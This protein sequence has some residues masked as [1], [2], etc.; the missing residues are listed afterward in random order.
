MT[1]T[2]HP[3]SA[4]NARTV[5][6]EVS[7]SVIPGTPGDAGAIG[8]VTRRDLV[9][10]RLDRLGRRTDE[11]DPFG[12]DRPG[13]V[14]VLGEEAVAG[15]HAVGA[16][17]PDRGEDRLGVEVPL[18]GRLPAERVGLVG[19]PHVQR[20]AVEVGVDRDGRDAELLGTRG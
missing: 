17:R 12:R 7:G 10:H 14:G 15:V 6:G 16:A 20:V 9:A 18:G 13:E 19:Q 1:A 11:R 4:P 3:C 5:S 2:G 8:S